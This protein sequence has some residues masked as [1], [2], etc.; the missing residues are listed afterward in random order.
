MVHLVI[1][2]H[3]LALIEVFCCVSVCALTIILHNA[4]CKF[5]FYSTICQSILFASL[6][7]Y[8]VFNPSCKD[9]FAPVFQKQQFLKYGRCT[10]TLWVL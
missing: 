3:F 7:G 2:C 4:L 5:T 9:Y 8:H 1:M 6:N 10:Q